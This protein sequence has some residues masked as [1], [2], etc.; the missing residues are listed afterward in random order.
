[1]FTVRP[2]SACLVESEI[3]DDVALHITSVATGSDTSLDY[4]MRC[5]LCSGLLTERSTCDLCVVFASESSYAAAIA[6]LIQ[7]RLPGRSCFQVPRKMDPKISRVF[8]WNG[9]CPRDM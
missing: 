2:R 6:Y 4:A 1:M 5:V 9:R 3:Y 7:P 8:C